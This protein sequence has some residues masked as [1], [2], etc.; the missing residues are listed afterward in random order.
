[1]TFVSSQALFKVNQ[2][3]LTLVATHSSLQTNIGCFSLCHSQQS[4]IPRGSLSAPVG[5]GFSSSSATNAGSIPIHHFTALLTA[6]CSAFPD[7]DFSMVCPWNFKLVSSPEQAQANINWAFECRL[8]NCDI[9]LNRLWAVL[10]KEIA[11]GVC[12]IYFYEPDRPDGFSESGAVFNMCYFFLNER[13]GKVVIVHLLEGGNDVYE[14]EETI[15][16]YF[17]YGVF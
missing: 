8:Q 13:A 9:A 14:D 3:F 7:F 1:M 4:P 6:F 5:P 12:S 2:E 10:E 17:G 15:E 11:P 16:E